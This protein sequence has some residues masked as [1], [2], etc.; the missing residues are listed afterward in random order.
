LACSSCEIRC[1]K[2]LWAFVKVV[3]G[4]EIYNFSYYLLGHFSSIVWSKCW[5]NNA[6]PNLNLPRNAPACDVSG[7]QCL[8][9]A[10]TAVRAHR[11]RLASHGWC[12]TPWIPVRDSRGPVGRC[13]VAFPQSPDGR[14]ALRHWPVGRHTSPLPLAHATT[15]T[16]TWHSRCHL[17]SPPVRI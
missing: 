11:D 15:C 9:P 5:S 2:P 7:A 8:L 13:H 14:A 16:A 3:E 10:V 17:D 4:S 6:K 1:S 12:T